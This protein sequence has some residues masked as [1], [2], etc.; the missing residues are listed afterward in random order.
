MSQYYETSTK[1][2]YDYI[3]SNK[4][5]YIYEIELIDSYNNSIY[6]RKLI[7]DLSGI[8]LLSQ[9]N[10]NYNSIKQYKITLININNMDNII[11]HSGN[12]DD[13][14]T[15]CFIKNVILIKFINIDNLMNI[16]YRI[17]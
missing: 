1:Y 6:I 15:L 11:T 4:I 13:N 10:I 14:M 16:S 5:I 9:E 2:K 7:K 17:I 3:E 8:I 12:I